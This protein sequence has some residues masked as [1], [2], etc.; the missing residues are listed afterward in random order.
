MV[1]EMSDR[2]CKGVV[3]G[4]KVG[5]RGKTRGQNVKRKK[6][7]ETKRNEFEAEKFAE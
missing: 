7:N 3:E 4:W 2:E 5:T 1:S 6:R